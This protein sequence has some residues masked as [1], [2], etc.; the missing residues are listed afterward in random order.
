MKRRLQNW[1]NRTRNT[2]GA[3]RNRITEDPHFLNVLVQAEMEKGRFTL[4]SIPPSGGVDFQGIDTTCADYP[5]GT[6]VGEVP[7]RMKC[8]QLLAVVPAVALQAG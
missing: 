5:A 7:L 4:E 3:A 6:N 1:I 8:R 2:C